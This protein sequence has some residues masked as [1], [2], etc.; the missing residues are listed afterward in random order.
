V[1][2]Q[3]YPNL[4]YIIID[5]GS[6]DE[7]LAIIKKYEQHLAYWISEPDKGQTDA[8]NKG[9]AKCTGEIFN[10][11]NSDDYYEQGALHKLAANFSSAKDVDVVAGREWG[12]Q[13]GDEANRRLHA[14]SIICPSLFDSIL[15][16][17]IDQPCTFFRKQKIE[18]F[19]PLD[20][21]LRL[22]M[23]RQLWWQYL[24]S[25]GQEKIVVT[26]E[27]FT[28]FRLHAK[29]KTVSEASMVE[30]EFDRLKKS[31]FMHLQ[32]PDILTEQVEY[33]KPASVGW[34]VAVEPK[35][36]ILA[37]FA[38]YYARRNY[39]QE[40]LPATRALMKWVQRWKGMGMSRPEWKLWVSSVLLPHQLLMQL[41]RAKHSTTA[42]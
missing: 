21:S 12:F 28:H 31:L 19:F 23:D 40:N 14:G 26:D 32:A 41:K 24:L 36:H 20:H 13:D 29:S 37:A 5:G 6:T 18:R 42:K 2:S 39:V 27:V 11:L 10:W 38:A 9:F 25:F 30:V 3:G 16:G 35:K 17:I 8:I 1:L 34:Q 22:V 7:T 4:E 15:T 33:V